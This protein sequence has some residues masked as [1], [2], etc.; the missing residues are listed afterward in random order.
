MSLWLCYVYDAD[1]AYVI[2]L[3]LYSVIITASLFR[4]KT[5]YVIHHTKDD[6][7]SKSSHVIVGPSIV[8]A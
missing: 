5:L 2:A 4:L 1:A 7:S 8:S 3:L 6:A